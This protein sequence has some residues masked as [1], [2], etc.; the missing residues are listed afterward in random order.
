MLD[1]LLKLWISDDSW[2]IH[3]GANRIIYN[4]NNSN[5]IVSDN[6]TEMM[7]LVPLAVA[8]TLNYQFCNWTYVKEKSTSQVFHP[9]LLSPLLSGKKQTLLLAI[10]AYII[11][12]PVV[13]FFLL[14]QQHLS[15]L[16]EIWFD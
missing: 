1:L 6:D 12:K 15:L 8:K 4:N 11:P 16:W 13:C 10:I 7:V 2:F 3:L 5:I 14:E 9:L